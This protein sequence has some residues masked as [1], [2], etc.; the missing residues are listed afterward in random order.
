MTERPT[1]S[2]AR[3]LRRILLW[4][5]HTRRFPRVRHAF[6][7]VVHNTLSHPIL[8]LLPCCLTVWFHD[9]T[10]KHL[11]VRPQLRP[12]RMPDIPH[13][14]KWLWH[15]TVGH[16]AIGLCPCRRTFAFHDRTSRAMEVRGW[17]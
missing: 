8:G 4:K 10:A 12:S 17:V 3:Y 15:N 5:E 11:N 16:I 13:F 6:W 14:P 7:W 2:H 9:W 1:G